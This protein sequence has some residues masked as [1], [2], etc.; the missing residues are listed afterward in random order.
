[1][2]ATM[3]GMIMGT[4][5]YM[6]PEQARGHNVDRRADIWA[7]GV[8]V[9]ELLTG[10][11]L[12]EADT[13]TDTL[14]AVLTKEPDLASI[15]E[16]VR[17]LL[18]RCL[19]RDPRQ[20]LRD[21]GDA[22]FLLNE[23]PHAAPPPAP[24]RRL[25]PGLA[26]AATVAACVFAGLWL[27]P[28]PPPRPYRFTLDTTG[29]IL[30]SPNGRWMVN[31]NNGLRLRSLEGVRWQLLAG[32]EGAADPFWS[33]D[34][35]TIG[36]FSGG[37]L[38]SVSLDGTNLRNL[39]PAPESRGGSWRGGVTDGTILYA[40]G[41]QLQTFDIR[42]LK[43]SPLAL[44][45]SGSDLPT[46]PVFCPQGENF[47]Y[48]VPGLRSSL[49]RSSLSASAP[50]QRLLDT[51]YGVSFARHPHTGKWHIFFV[52]TDSGTGISNRT[53]VTAAIDPGTC[54]LLSEPE[55]VVDAMSNWV[56]TNYASFDVAAA[57]IIYWRATT[58]SLP[59]WRLRWFDRNGNVTGTIGDAAG[60]ASISLSPDET[61][62]AALQGYPEQHIWIYNFQNGTG[63]RLSASSGSE[64][65]PVWSPDGRSVYYVSAS[66][67][68][69]RVIRHP[70][71]PGASPEVLFQ[72]LP[73]R[74]LSIEDVTPDGRSL[75][76]MQLGPG[77]I[78]VATPSVFRLDLTIPEAARK[79]EPL[80]TLP[81]AAGQINSRVSPDGRFIVV[82]IGG[83][84]YTARYPPAGDA[85]HQVGA[86][87]TFTWPFFSRDSHLLYF[88]SGQSLYSYPVLA[89]PGQ[90][91]RLGERSVLFKLI[92]PAR[93]VANIGAASRD[94]NRFLAIA[95]DETDEIR[96]QVHSDWT[97]LLSHPP[98]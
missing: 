6:A 58:P 18:R 38:R 52:R 15:P 46:L 7:F 59:I 25:L 85:L 55:P 8:V 19:Q 35:S 57:G 13:V 5:A 91:M 96:I 65:N 3:A 53:L 16:R 60:Y 80:Y 39:A 51:R 84:V 81:N 42:S 72:N 71:E 33:P 73:D 22:A 50:A 89:P 93:A 12:F 83:A 70:A 68:S 76:L 63:S 2:R 75:I 78:N 26:I 74:V 82:V 34:S 24:R 56:G 62:L 95:T 67:G 54:A 37:R 41:G 87:S 64:S 29:P 90:G 20:R 97:A 28:A 44:R 49:F 1:M 10:K 11:Q 77:Q 30:F 47:V 92:H 61:R 36:F 79:L 14:A 17:P 23:T 45:F 98:K 86:F 66:E 40:A 94:G 69:S 32:S 27:R 9:Y 48:T 88:I 21:I 31:V 43:V 4:A